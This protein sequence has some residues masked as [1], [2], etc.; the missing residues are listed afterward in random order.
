MLNSHNT[1]RKSQFGVLIGDI[2]NMADEF[3]EYNYNCL[4]VK[5]KSLLSGL[6]NCT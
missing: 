6:T 5:N 4:Q 3:N 2:F 1:Y